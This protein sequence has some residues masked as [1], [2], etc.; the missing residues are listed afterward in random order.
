MTHIFS[1]FYYMG[2]TSVTSIIYVESS[3]WGCELSTFENFLLN[4]NCLLWI[5]T[6][7]WITGT[8]VPKNYRYFKVLT[9]IKYRSNIFKIFSICTAFIQGVPLQITIL[10]ACVIIFSYILRYSLKL[11]VRFVSFTQFIHLYCCKVY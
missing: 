2:L 8:T 7:T 6:V 5:F 1:F 3:T 4:A 9:F 11:T 10:Y